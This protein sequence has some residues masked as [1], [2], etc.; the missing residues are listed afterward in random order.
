VSKKN[1]K[2]RGATKAVGG[3]ISRNGLSEEKEADFEEESTKKGNRSATRNEKPR[4]Q[5]KELGKKKGPIR[6]EPAT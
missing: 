3:Q 4:R 6:R 2:T 5:K 1:K